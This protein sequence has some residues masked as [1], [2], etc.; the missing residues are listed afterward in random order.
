[1]RDHKKSS[2][3]APGFSLIETLVAATIVIVALAA[4]AQLFVIAVAANQRAKS[5]TV[6][7]V[8]A[9]AKL[10]ELMAI[11]GNV[12]AGTDFIDGRGQWIGTGDSPLPGTVYIRRWVAKPL[13]ARLGAWLLHVSVTPA[14]HVVGGEAAQIVGA[15]T[16]RISWR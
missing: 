8:L 6:A 14:S 16:W 12:P 11:D 10:E 2:N 7:T 9:Q 4:L 15:K 1:M 13:P 3:G 5:S